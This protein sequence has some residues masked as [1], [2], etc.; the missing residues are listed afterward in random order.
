MI[1]IAEADLLKCCGSTRWAREMAAHSFPNPKEVLATADS[2][3]WSL[4]PA[5]WMEAFRAHP[6]IGERSESKWSQ[7]EQHIA[8]HASHDILGELR[9][10]NSLYEERFGY[11]FIVC[12]TGKSADQMLRM[13]RERLDND[14]ESELRNAAEQQRQITHL[15]LKRLVN[16]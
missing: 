3:W 6:R 5:D 1:R 2:V 16:R 13:M 8:R 14:P 4:A 11:I 10:A 9:E 7:E 15:R 12:A